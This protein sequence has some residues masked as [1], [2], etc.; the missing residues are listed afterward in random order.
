MILSFLERVSAYFP[1]LSIAFLG[2]IFIVS[3][4]F[5]Y[6]RHKRQ[7]TLLHHRQKISE[8]ALE[9]KA[10]L[11]KILNNISMSFMET[12]SE[13]QFNMVV[14]SMLAQ[15][16]GYVCV[17][18]L[19]IFLFTA[20]HRDLS[21]THEWCAPG[22][23]TKKQNYKKLPP[24]SIPWIISSL[25]QNDHIILPDVGELPTEARQ[26]ATMFK[27]GSDHT[28]MMVP[29]RAR[30]SL[31]GFIGFDFLEQPWM[32]EDI[33]LLRSLSIIL[34]SAIYRIRAE[35]KLLERGEK[36]LQYQT[37]L[38]SLVIELTLAEERERRKVANDLHDQIGQM[39]AVVKI[40]Q[41][42]LAGCEE[43]S[44]SAALSEEIIEMIDQVLA[45]VRSLTFELSALAVHRDDINA[46]IESL[47]KKVLTGHGINA[48]FQTTG[49]PQVLPE[50]IRTIL[51]QVV[52]ELF[53][54]IVK[55]AQATNVEITIS[56]KQ[57]NV[58]IM[59]TDDGI[60]FETK[61]L[62]HDARTG[63]FGLFNVQ[64][65]VSSLTGTFHIH[66][67]PGSGT[68]AEL[69]IQVPATNGE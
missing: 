28:M 46:A 30:T 16:G 53:Y 63:H 2:F 26:E 35:S 36:L 51:Y 5:F 18:R 1:Q 32:D 14:D 19:Y 39:L 40:K 48:I 23:V 58:D 49:P 64:E 8:E 10:G 61:E 7:D 69:S 21:N 20:D 34:G 66:S 56:R 41:K 62:E 45:D 31:I 47:G 33:N 3:I 22:I 57:N 52:R 15:V 29:I 17:D 60:G 44:E 12:G 38:K 68:T 24:E 42:K 55:H 50:H 67:V 4:I 11:E 25:Q 43:P 37:R 6:R 9:Y 54:N 13:N 59:V 65:R 27:R